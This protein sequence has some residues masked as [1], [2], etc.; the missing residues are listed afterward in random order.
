MGSK[1]TQLSR[2]ALGITV[3]GIVLTVAVHA[4]ADTMI[5]RPLQQSLVLQHSLVFSAW[6][7]VCLNKE[8]WNGREA[9]CFTSKNGR[10]EF[11][12]S[13]VAAV[14]I[15]AGMDSEKICVSHCHL[16]CGSRMAHGS[17]SITVSP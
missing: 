15:D 3:V 1:Q 8:E 2:R 9:A 14:L 17:R 7:K 6:T 11:G 5:S 4:A 10:T 12:L 16:E 13:F